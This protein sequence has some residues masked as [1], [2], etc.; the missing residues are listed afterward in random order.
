ML[1]IIR[2]KY[3]VNLWCLGFRDVGLPLSGA[4][5]GRLTETGCHKKSLHVSL[6]MLFSLACH[7]IVRYL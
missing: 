4:E 1:L 5:A 6:C 3:V 7:K 2:N